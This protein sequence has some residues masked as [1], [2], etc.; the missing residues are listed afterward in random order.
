MEN[1][2]ALSPNPLVQYLD[3][4]AEQFTKADLIRYIEENGIELINFR[5]AGGDGRLKELNFVVTSAEQ[6]DQILSMGER[7]DGSSLFSHIPAGSSDLYV[8]P[9]YRTAFLN[10]FSDIPS[11]DI[12][13][14]FFNQY[15][16]PW[17]DAPQQILHKAHQ[18]LQERT[19][20]RLESLGE[21]E[22]Y[23]ISALDDLFEAG[24]Q[25]GYHEA[26]PFSKFSDFRKEAMLAIAQSGG[27]MKYGHSE[28]GNFTMGGLIYEQNEIEFNP[29][30][31]EDAADQMVVAKWILRTL[32]HK[33]GYTVTFAPKITIGKAGSGLHIHNRLMKGDENI[34]VKDGH[35]SDTARKFIA[36]M[37]DLSPSL[38]AFGNTNPTSY[39]RLVPH[40]EAPT[41]ICWGDRN[42]SVLVRVPLGWR[43]NVNMA[44][45]A[46]PL[47]KEEEVNFSDKQTVEF[48]CPDGSADIYL[49]MAGLTV[50]A[51]HGLEMPSALELA[52][53]TYVDVDIFKKENHTKVQQL[54]QLPTSCWDSAEELSRQRSIYEQYGVFSPT[55]IDRVILQ[56]KSFEDNNIREQLTSHKDDMIK[57]VDQFFHCG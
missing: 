54:A 56:L 19:G 47:E 3:K 1:N 52:E 7:V 44:R 5:Y 48:R 15:G 39:F 37:L 38:T 9:R 20:F 6:I 14:S 43:N 21:L 18:N 53:K 22:Y 32:A 16:E 57:L 50:A 23:V 2:F 34:L 13:C 41:S 28:V 25:R 49:L 42:R 30:P 40:Q 46:N 12:L 51:R 26:E 31:V 33:Y 17:S 35:L 11:L 29:V 24:D 55:L 10:P 27:I 8:I 4:P 45:I 36:G